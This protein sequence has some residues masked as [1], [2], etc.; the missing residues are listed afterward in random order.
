MFK[1][2]KKITPKS[3]EMIEEASDIIRNAEDDE[4]AIAFLKDTLEDDYPDLDLGRMNLH[5][6]I[7]VLSNGN[8]KKNGNIKLVEDLNSS[9]GKFIDR[10]EEKIQKASIKR[11]NTK[12]K[13]TKRKSKKSRKQR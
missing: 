12:H 13:N 5:E 8:K 10:Q 2:T 3:K 4:A 11:K 1:K 6:A 9:L 7:D